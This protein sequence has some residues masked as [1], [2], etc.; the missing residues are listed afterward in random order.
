MTKK[1]LVTGSTKGIGFEIVN[2]F[3]SNNWEVCLTGRNQET[4]TEICNSMNIDKLKKALGIKT[5]FLK[6]EDIKF[7]F[8]QIKS[9]WTDLDCI[10]FNVGD[11]SGLKGIKSTADE[12]ERIFELNFMQTYKAVNILRYLLKPNAQSSIIFIG[13][14]AA[15]KNVKA[16]LNYAMAK[17]SLTTFTKVLAKKLASDGIRV[18]C[19]NPGHILTK[20]GVWEQKQL[21][22]QK[23]FNEFVGKN[24][25]LGQIGSTRDIADA[26]Y[27]IVNLENNYLSGNSINVDGGLILNY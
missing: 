2:L 15:F 11:G 6:N 17:F 7:L 19:I 16:P 12:N 21:N 1:I 25:P 3:R 9:E 14:I 5:N 8:N 18:N 13:S 24:I 23:E 10:V 27:S 22:S 26:V 4:L 20:G